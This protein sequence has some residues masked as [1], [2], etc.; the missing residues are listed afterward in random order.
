M[1]INQVVNES[2]QLCPECGGPAF[3]D[4][5]LAEKQDAC[6]HKVRSRYKVW[7]SAYAS[8]AL[9]QCRKKGAANWGNKSKNEDVAE[10]QLDE[11]S[12]GNYRNKASVSRGQSQMGAMF[13]NPEE[14]AKHLATFNKRD[15]G[16]ARADARIK[17]QRAAD[18]A[19]QLA[20]LVARLPELKA[21]YER[22]RAE[23]KSL[24]GS[25]WQYAD[26]EQNLTDY[27]RKA[28]SM[29]GPMNNLWR[30]IQ[31]AEK[32]QGQ[33]GVAEG[34]DDEE[35]PIRDDGNEGRPGKQRY[36]GKLKTKGVAEGSPRLLSNHGRRWVSVI[37]RTDYHFDPASL[38][39]IPGEHRAE[40]WGNDGTGALI[41]FA[42]KKDANYFIL[43]QGGEVV[44]QFKPT[45]GPDAVEQSVDEG[46][47]KWGWHTS[48]TNG[49]FM[50]TKYGNKAYVY[51]HD[52]DSESPR[53]G[54]QLVTVNKPTV[55]KRIAQ[56]FGAKV[57]KTDLNTYRIVKPATQDVA[58]G[59]LEEAHH[60]ALLNPKKGQFASV[61][62][63]SMWDSKPQIDYYNN[64]D[65]AKFSTQNASAYHGSVY[66]W[67]GARWIR[68][69]SATERGSGYG[70]GDSYFE[71][72]QGV[73]EG[74]ISQLEKDIAD[75]PVKPIASME[76]ATD[77]DGY[78]VD[79]EDAGEYDYEG[80]QAK[81]QLQTIVAA[82]R[83]LDGILDDNEN[84]PEWVQMKITK[85][86]DY[87]D[88][89]ADYVAANKAQAEPMAEGE[90]QKIGG[91][92]DPDEFD[93]MV[94]RLK[95]LA[96]AGPLKTVWDPEKRVY[97][98]VPTA[99][100]PQGKK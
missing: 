66:A 28:R 36:P 79:Q 76:S 24:G 27:E 47:D 49:E 35:H 95:K 91:R 9:V 80:D 89:A 2:P 44:K 48:L 8:G 55:A 40:Y 45:M 18:Q 72:E 61:I 15:A 14:K 70:Y 71:S 93:A 50:P 81:D 92:Y 84:M 63:Q 23:Y 21:E 7:P 16:I 74:D 53:G 56:Q 57:V 100:Q 69:M 37:V 59:S 77:S 5:V 85:A 75:A 42:S 4:L 13:G 62:F 43:K 64:L 73:S 12:L 26:R 25:D 78:S 3:S 82:A 58:E 10:D 39:S 68:K 34:Y 54:P 29:E 94:G 22:M 67:N 1:K 31:A 96:G 38:N 17:K 99:V 52:L 30:Q 90:P 60:G 33:Q 46:Y 32:A 19:A 98:N 6:Y 51:L 86:T 83:K 88:T 87:L 41:A 11:I 65:D 20:D 97:K